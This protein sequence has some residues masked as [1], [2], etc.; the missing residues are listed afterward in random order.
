[1]NYF[2]LTLGCIK[3]LKSC[4]FLFNFLG[5]I[6]TFTLHTAF[7]LITAVIS[8]ITAGILGSTF[9]FLT[10]FLLFTAVI[11]WITAIPFLLRSTFT[12]TVQFL[13][14]TLSFPAAIHRSTAI[15]CRITTRLLLRSTSIFLTA[16]RCVTA[17]CVLVTAIRR[18]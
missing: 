11:I 4:H 18:S 17:G 16:V 13:G 5:F 12:F 15:I 1:V 6:S 14:D 9:L 2:K 8:R 7:L 10:T 3:C